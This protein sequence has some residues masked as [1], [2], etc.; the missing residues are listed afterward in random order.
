M[1]TLGQ[2]LRYAVRTLISSRSLTLVAVLSLA[3]GI[4]ANTTIFTFVDALLLKPPAVSN[5]SRLREVWQHNTTRGNGIGSHMQL[6]YPDFEFYRDHNRVFEQMAAFSGETSD[7]IWNRGGEGE[8]LRGALVSGDFFSVLGVRPALGRGFLPEEDRRGSATPV[9]VL[10]HAT[11]QQRLGGDRGII[12][13]P[14]TLNGRPFTVVGIAPAGFTGLLAGFAPEFWAPVAMHDAISPALS[15]TERRQHWILG[16]GR[17]REG[18]APAQVNADLGILGEQLA[19]DFPDADR[20]LAPNALPVD[21]VPSP[22]RGVAGGVSGVLMAL[23]ALVLLIACANVANLL[24]AKASSRRSEMAVRSALGATRARLIRQIL[25][26]SGLIALLAGGVGLLLALWATPLLLSLKP[27]SLPIFLDISLDVRVLGFTLFASLVTGIAFGLAPAL[28]QSRRSHTDDLKDGTPGGGYARSRLRNALVIAQVAA[29]VFLL[30]GASL[31]VRS[32]ANASSID[33]GF[34]T[35]NAVAASLNVEPFGYDEA[36]GRIFYAR[37]IERVRALPGVRAAAYIDHMPLGQVTEMDAVE[38]D[39]GGGAS[40]RAGRPIVDT[41]MVSPDYFAA[42][43]TPILR[44]RGFTAADDATAAP[45]VVV[46][47]EMARR[48]WPGQ[49]AVGRFVTLSGPR[50][51]RVRAQVVGIAKTGRYASLGEDPKPFFYRAL[52]QAYQPGVQLVVRTDGQVPILAA[53]REQ[54]HDLDSRLALMGAETLEQHMQLPLFP[55]RASGLFLGIVGLLALALALLGLYAVMSYLV[56]QRTREIGV[57]MALG[58]R[59]QDV[60]RLV[61]W[62]GLRLTFL[63]TGLGVVLALAGTRVLSNVLYGIKPSDPISYATVVGLLTLAAALA[64]YVP[65]RWATRVDPIR[66]L[67]TQ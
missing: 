45:V 54:V 67:R 59:P 53:L 64:S 42:M 48:F 19:R 8:P 9:I 6:S 37:L 4:G 24:L 26:E 34:D 27:A 65:A 49:D 56:S 50:Q 12:G 21:L 41:A 23:V 40:D 31:C 20:H 57:R 28:R 51:A 43:G 55:A 18:V 16:L 1:E 61:V 63:G 35:R 29:C 13:R 25:T 46:N 39:T 11:W 36:R 22:F 66:A 2:D 10:S 7:V 3:I 38:P 5:P 58:A 14:L 47:E 62:Q 32:L 60:L 44:G 17:I 52:L 33:P 30:V 15:L